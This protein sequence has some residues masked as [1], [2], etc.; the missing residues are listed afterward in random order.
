V[1]PLIVPDPEPAVADG[2]V[3]DAVNALV[4]IAAAITIAAHNAN[5]QTRFP[6]PLLLRIEC[7]LV[8]DDRSLG[9]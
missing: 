9:Y 1:Y 3:F 7:P 6:F 5:R 8:L 2:T 4:P